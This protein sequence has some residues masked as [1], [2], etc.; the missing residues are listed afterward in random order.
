MINDGWIMTGGKRR[1]QSVSHSSAPEIRRF[2]NAK[3]DGENQYGTRTHRM[4]RRE[5][6]F[7]Q[8][9]RKRRSLELTTR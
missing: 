1:T 3:P 8:M 5:S 4:R 9:S 7:Q 2:R 6:H